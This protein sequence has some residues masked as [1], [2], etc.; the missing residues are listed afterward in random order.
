MVNPFIDDRALEDPDEER[1][2]SDFEGED[3]TGGSDGKDTDEEEF[4]WMSGQGVDWVDED[5]TDPNRLDLQQFSEYLEERY[6]KSH[7]EPRDKICPI[8]DRTPDDKLEAYALKQTLLALET[9]QMFWRVRCQAGEEIQLVFDILHHELDQNTTPQ[10]EQG[11]VVDMDYSHPISQKSLVHK[12][13]ESIRHFAQSSTMSIQEI[14]YQVSII[15]EEDPL[16]DLW[17]K[18]IDQAVIEPDEEPL[19]GLTRFEEIV[20]AL[21]SSHTKDSAPA[22][23]QP[24]AAL[25]H[26]W[27]LSAF[28]APNVSGYVYLEGNLGKDPQHSNIVEFLRSHSAVRKSSLLRD[29]LSMGFRKQSV[30]VEPVSTLEVSQLLDNPPP[31]IRP[32]TW[33]C[34]VT[35]PYTDDVG[36]V[37]RREIT[38]GQRRLVVL[39]VPRLPLPS[40][41]ATPSSSHS[42]HPGTQRKDVNVTQTTHHKPPSSG[43]S[44]CNTGKR[45]RLLERHPRTLFDP[46]KF[47]GKYEKLGP[48]RYRT[49]KG[50]FNHGLL[51]GYLAYNSVTDVNITMDAETRRLFLA[52]RHPFLQY[53]HLPVASD[54]RF[55]VNDRVEVIHPAPLSISNVLHPYLPHTA[56]YRKEATIYTVEAARCFVQFSEYGGLDPNDTGVWVENI[57]IRKMF[58]TGDMVLVEAGEYEGRAGLVMTSYGNEI[59]VAE[60]G[61]RHG[62]SFFIDP[63]MCRLSH[64]RNDGA[65]PWVNQHVTI[66]RG[67]YRRYMGVVVDIFP[68]RPYTLLAINIPQ[69]LQT[70]RV[71]HDDVHDTYAQ[72][73]LQEVHPLSDKQQYFKQ[74]SWGLTPAPNITTPIQDPHTRQPVLPEDFLKRQP[75]QP[76]LNQPVIV[77][78][79]AIK[80]TGIVK[81]V[82]RNQHVPS[83]LVVRVEMNFMS[84]EHGA[85]PTFDFDYS[86]LRDP[87][88]GL[89]LHI[90]HPLRG[91][92]RYWE[93]LTRVKAVSVPNPNALKPCTRPT[94]APST[95]PWN[96]RVFVDPFQNSG[97]GPS[98][99][100]SS[101][102]PSHWSLDPRLDGKEFFVCWKPPTGPGMSKVIAK[103]ECRFDRIRLTD[104]ADS[105]VVPPAE[106]CDVAVPILP[107]TNRYPLVVIRGEHTGKNLRQFFCKYWPNEEEPR[108]MAAVYSGWGTTAER[109]L[110]DHVEVEAK[111]FA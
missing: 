8:L 106:I 21:I 41:S 109:K 65:T 35:G 28:T 77:V 19:A 9:T 50:E 22:R 31:S 20:L 5:D 47:I 32:L 18:A 100:V 82:Q 62:Q 87:I 53:V 68:P 59:V 26:H 44:I 33:V 92:M 15:L 14:V 105:W 74:A 51:V 66:I 42:E 38:S 76:W 63:N 37:L 108:I 70:I 36:V 52:S 71:R 107:K 75:D 80:T 45:K 3:V 1:Y 7:T 29:D 94:S 23:S 83:G 110:E 88:T 69:L 48:L 91:R 64:V 81:E 10:P 99:S 95:P 34:I 39:L 12:A 104:G 27:V 111:D 30:N 101:A 46:S 72:K 93:P 43:Y 97:S 67:P 89:P 55:F 17:R 13:I 86:W 84:A 85:S 57:N 78:K 103:P 11:L 25:E 79:G 61:L 4:D 49:S 102:S 2:G 60:T 73:P 90:R 24:P 54:W 6:A 96:N 58:R 16:P 56:T 98:I 40:T